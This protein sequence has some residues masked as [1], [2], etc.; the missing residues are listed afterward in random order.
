MSTLNDFI[1]SV[2]AEGLMV[3][4]KF[5]VDIGVPLI[6]TSKNLYVGDLRKVQ[7]YCDNVTLPGMSISTTQ[8]R[9]FGEIREMPHER[10]FDNVTMNFYVDNG[11]HTKLFFDTWIQSIQDPF[12]RKFNYY[13]EYISDISINVF[14][15]ASN[16]RYIVTLY[17]CYPKSISPIT[18]DYSSKEVMK[19]Q[20]SMNY[21]YWL[22]NTTDEGSNNGTTLTNSNQNL[23]PMSIPNDYFTDFPNYQASVNSFENARASLY[24]AEPLGVTTGLGS[25]LT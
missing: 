10:L 23:D 12:T 13:K 14:D 24:E 17:E 2:A 7:L 22:S 21:K 25:I 1:A 9:T 15:A 11:M 19:L 5:S 4:S 6:I 16:Q 18:M 20:V 8:A 3:S